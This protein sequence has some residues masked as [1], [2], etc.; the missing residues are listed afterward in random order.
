LPTTAMA[1]YLYDV[2]ERIMVHKQVPKS[3]IEYDLDV[4]AYEG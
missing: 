1:D 2:A 3:Y 4:V